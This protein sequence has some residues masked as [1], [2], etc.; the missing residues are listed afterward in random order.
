MILAFA[1]IT[2]T[3]ALCAPSVFSD[4]ELCQAAIAVNNGH[5]AKSVK[6]QSSQKDNI[7]VSY[8]RPSDKKHFKF[9]CKIESNE[10]RW[11][12]EYIG[13]WSQNLRVY[14]KYLNNDKTLEV[15]SVILGDEQYAVIKTFTRNDFK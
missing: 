3:S 8:I 1:V 9:W 12:D 13:R 11:K 15:R 6:V 4:A 10:K 2:S 14:Y 5:S 7:E